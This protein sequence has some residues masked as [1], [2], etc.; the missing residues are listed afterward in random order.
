MGHASGPL[1]R[2]FNEFVVEKEYC[3]S[4]VVMKLKILQILCDDV[5]DVADL[6]AEIDNR[7]ESEVGFDTDGV[8]AELPEN[9][10]RRVHPR[11]A[12]TSASKEKELS[13]FVAVNHGISSLSDSKNWSSRY[14]DGGPNGD[15]PDLDA[16]SDECRLCGMDGTLLCCDGCP[17]AYHS[18]CIGVVKM[19]IPDGPWYCPEC[20][21][22]KMGPTVVYKTSLRGA[23]YFG[24]DPHGRLFLG[25]CNLLLVYVFDALFHFRYFAFQ[26]YGNRV[27]LS[28][29]YLTESC[30]C[31]LYFNNSH[32]SACLDFTYIACIIFCVDAD[33]YFA[34]ITG[35][36]LMSMRMQISNITMSPTFQ[37]L[38]WYFCL[39]RTIDWNICIYAKR[40]HNT[41]ICLEV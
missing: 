10:P 19:Y 17:L 7:E 32:S 38:S 5:F 34:Y 27:D 35:L 11:F 12:K 30:F 26:I 24:V 14:T 28:V 33:E 13:E 37:K 25:T 39:Q 9:G 18:R 23:V 41:G 1:W 15:S 4:P 31:T 3:S 2:F 22:K 20:T 8:T 6:R 40:S 36:K 16:N 29:L 21:I